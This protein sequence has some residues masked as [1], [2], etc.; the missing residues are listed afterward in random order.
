MPP[1]PQARGFTLIEVLAALAILAM[2][3]AFALRALSGALMLTDRGEREQAALSV[4]ESVLDRV[5][6]DIEVREGEQD[7]RTA[8]GFAWQV[9]MSSYA[10]GAGALETRPPAAHGIIVDVTVS[11]KAQRYTRKLHLSTLRLAPGG[12]P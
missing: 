8:D 5:G 10:N 2:T 3:A 7:G 12:G 4:A 6:R 9:R 1:V 11:W